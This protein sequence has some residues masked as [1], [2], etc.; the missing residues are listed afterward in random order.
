MQSKASSEESL[1]PRRRPISNVT[2]NKGSRRKL[3]LKGSSQQDQGCG[4][5]LGPGEA[6]PR[7]LCAALHLSPQGYGG[8]GPEQ[9]NETEEGAG[10]KVV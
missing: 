10:G 5:A 4:S 8:A 7:A 3:P 1:Q 2:S 6:L 9:S